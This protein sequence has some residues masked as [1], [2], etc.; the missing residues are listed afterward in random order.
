MSVVPSRM[1]PIAERTA[2]S[3]AKGPRIRSL[4]DTIEVTIIKMKQRRYGGAVIP[5]A[6]TSVK[7]PISDTMVGRNNGRDAKLTLL[8]KFC[9]ANK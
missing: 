6:W 9:R 1:K 7:V 8:Q 2:N 5:F 3:A 4:S